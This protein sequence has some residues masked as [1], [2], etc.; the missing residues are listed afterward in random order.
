MRDFLIPKMLEAKLKNLQ[1]A[2]SKLLSTVPS[3]SVII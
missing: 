2:G 3:K 1:Q